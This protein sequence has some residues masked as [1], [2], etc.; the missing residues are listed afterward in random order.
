[1]YNNFNWCNYEP[2][3]V[4]LF[5]MFHFTIAWCMQVKEGVLSILCS[6]SRIILLLLVRDGNRLIQ[7]YSYMCQKPLRNGLLV[8]ANT[9]RSMSLSSEVRQMVEMIM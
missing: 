9:I 3:L 1:M 7:T 8:K 5:S 4:V 2:L 6:R